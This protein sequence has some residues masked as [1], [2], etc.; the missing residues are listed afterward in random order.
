MATTKATNKRATKAAPKTA[1]KAAQPAPATCAPAPVTRG[2]VYSYA[3]Q[4]ATLQLVAAPPSGM[5]TDQH[6]R[7]VFCQAA[8]ANGP[9]TVAEFCATVQGGRRTYRRAFRAGF[10]AGH[11]KQQHPN[12]VAA[13]ELAAQAANK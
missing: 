13:A 5:G 2:R 10:F 8:L 1:A 7:W 12:K 6:A 3:G 4:E 11:G 9:L